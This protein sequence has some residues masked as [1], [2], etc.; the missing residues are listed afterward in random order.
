[1]ASTSPASTSS[2]SSAAPRSAPAVAAA[3]RRAG[4]RRHRRPHDGPDLAPLADAS[5]RPASSSSTRPT[6]CS[7]SASSRTSRRSCGCARA[8]RQTA[9]FSATMPPPIQQLA[10]GYMYDPIDDPGHAEDTHRRR[11]RAGLRRGR[12]RSDKT[13]TLVELLKPKNPSRRS[14][15]PAPRSAP[16]QLDRRPRRD[17]GLD[18]QGAARRHEPGRPRRRDDRLQGPPR[19]GSWWRPTSPRADSTSST[20][21]T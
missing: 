21:P 12:A 18:V 9:L 4:R 17:K 14:S 11:D 10:E 7:T 3:S 5:P 16:R 13:D 8:G 6:R 20:S 15:S 19:A 2:P 1:M